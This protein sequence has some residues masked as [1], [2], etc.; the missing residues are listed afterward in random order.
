MLSA[1]RSVSLKTMTRVAKDMTAI[2]RALRR[3][4]TSEE[5][6]IWQRIRHCQPRF[7]RQLPVG[8]YIIDFACRSLKIAVELDGAQHLG[9]GAYD[10]ER[11]AFLES[12]GWQVLRFWN[13]E[14][15]ENPEGVADAILA[16]V[17]AKAGRPTPG[18]S[19]PG[20]GG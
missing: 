12:L 16:A 9:A 4:A 13:A 3:E 6:A 17:A 8:R 1:S 11:T 15:R 19:L 18:P 20:R 14:V 5:R 2:A 10:E 7:T